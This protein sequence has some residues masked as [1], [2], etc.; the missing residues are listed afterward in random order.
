M[1][2]KK[3]SEKELL[4]IDAMLTQRERKIESDEKNLRRREEEFKQKEAYLND[5]LRSYK[6]AIN[7]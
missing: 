1:P 7:G 5:R 4:D 3:V 6:K 2:L